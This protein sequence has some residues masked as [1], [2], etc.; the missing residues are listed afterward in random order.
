MS[1]GLDDEG[2]VQ[3]AIHLF[4]ATSFSG[5]DQDTNSVICVITHITSILVVSSHSIGMV[6]SSSTMATD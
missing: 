3:R 4:R 5:T 2:S 1:F 6:S